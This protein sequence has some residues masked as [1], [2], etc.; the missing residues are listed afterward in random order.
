M[1]S[2]LSKVFRGKDTNGV[3]SHSKK[4]AVDYTRTEIEQPRKPRW[5]DAW[6]RDS[7]APSEV[8]ELLNGCTKELKARGKPDKPR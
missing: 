8:Q 4:S 6:S 3:S 2:L 1:P 5:N 7:V